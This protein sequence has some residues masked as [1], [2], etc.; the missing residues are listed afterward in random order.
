MASG[1]CLRLFLEIADAA[2]LC[3]EEILT[4]LL[5]RR[6]VE[7]DRYIASL[8]DQAGSRLR[9]GTTLVCAVIREARL[10]F[11]SVG[12]SHLYRI[13]DNAIELL[14]EEH[15]YF[16]ELCKE[17]EAGERTLAEAQNDPKR[18]ALTSYI[19]IGNITKLHVPDSPVSLREG[20]LLLVCSDG[21]YRTLDAEEILSITTDNA[22]VAA[23][24]DALMRRVRAYRLPKQ[25]NTTFLLYRYVPSKGKKQ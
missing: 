23:L 20:E 9:A 2:C 25:D 6:A 3:D 12:D 24:A 22:P 19:G 7:A 8:R 18:D 13:R 4:E 14:T 1:E 5:R 17:V 11:V 16:A 10:Y 21:L 15:N